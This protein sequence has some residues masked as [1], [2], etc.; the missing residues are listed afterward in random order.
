MT[1]PKALGEVEAGGLTLLSGGIAD[2][3]ATSLPTRPRLAPWLTLVDLDEGRL[4]LRAAEFTLTIPPGLFADVTRHIYPLLDGTRSVSELADCGAPQFLPGT[5][6]FVLKF[7]QQ[8]GALHEGLPTPALSAELRLRH[9]S[10]LNLF[11]HYVGDAER[12]LFRL[13]TS[14]IALS[15]AKSI[16]TK[17]ETELVSV[18]VGSAAYLGPSATDNLNNARGSD[19]YIVASDTL[20]FRLFEAANSACLD[21]GIRWLRVAFEGRYGVVGPTVVPRQTACYTC[22]NARRASQEVPWEFEA[23]RSKLLSDGDPHEGTVEA[24]TDVVVA[25]AALEAVRLLT[26]FAPPSTFGRFHTFEAGTPRVQSHEVL[27][28]P[29]CTSCGRKQSP[30]DPWDLRSRMELE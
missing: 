23:Y 15:G 29:R 14:Q 26:G 5:I 3:A 12:V 22:Y 24:L 28:V 13:S 10:A 11:A 1:P 18:G 8:R 16:C 27:R 2:I 30:R 19:L 7:L 25:Q 4:Q 20:G 21:G 9:R 6:T 17:L